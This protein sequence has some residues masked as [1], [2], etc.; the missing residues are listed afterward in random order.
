MQTVLVTVQ[1]HQ[2]H[3]PVRAISSIDASLEEAGGCGGLVN[4]L[5]VRRRRANDR[6]TSIRTTHGLRM[7]A[8]SR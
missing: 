5:D 2:Q 4:D 1:R 8:F 7:I 3:V 6:Q